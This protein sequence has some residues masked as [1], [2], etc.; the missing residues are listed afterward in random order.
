MLIVPDSV[1]I[2][3]CR[4]A[5]GANSKAENWQQNVDE[6]EI[7]CVDYEQNEMLNHKKSRMYHAQYHKPRTGVSRHSYVK[8]WPDN[9]TA[10][11]RYRLCEKVRMI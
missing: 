8:R 2:T 6:Q 1:G 7:A 5:A 11:Q 4:A 10:T 3:N 9:T